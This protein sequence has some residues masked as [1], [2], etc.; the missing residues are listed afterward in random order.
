[1]LVR[2]CLVIRHS[3]AAWHLKMIALGMLIEALGLDTP[4][5][6]PYNLPPDY[7]HPIGVAGRCVPL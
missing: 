6:I 4:Q 2:I 7:T 1:M 3:R 5:P